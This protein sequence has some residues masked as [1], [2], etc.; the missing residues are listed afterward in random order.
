M[1][2]A[3]HVDDTHWDSLYGRAADTDLSWAQERPDLSLALLCVDGVAPRRVVD[4][5]AGRSRL[6]ECLLAAGSEHVTLVDL[7][8]TALDDTVSRVAAG[9]RSLIDTVVADVTTWEPSTTW[10]AW[11]DR[12][13]L[14]FLVDDGDRQRYVATATRAVLPG[15]VAVIGVF[16]PDGPEQCSGLPVRRSSADEI[17]ALFGPLWT[18]EHSEHETHRTPWGSEQSFTWVRLRRL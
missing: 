18:L 11:H 10:T 1:G 2:Y 16:A 4:V 17:H 9:S 7:S 8:A 15:G 12:A 6:A 14:H 5:G 13:V 3:G